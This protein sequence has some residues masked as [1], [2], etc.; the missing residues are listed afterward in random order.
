MCKAFSATLKVLARSW[1]RKL[2]PR[3]IDSFVNLSKLFVVNFM[4]CRV[5]QKN[6]SHLFTIHQKYGKNLKDYV[7]QFNQAILEVE[8]LSDKVVV[9]AMME[10]S[11]PG[12]LSNSLSQSVLE[13]LLA[14]QNKV[15]K[16]IA[17][18]ELAEAKRRRQGRD[19]HKKEG[20]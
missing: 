16:Y 9:M 18:E 19:D 11:H 12:P 13:T 20:T 1:F 8:D 5:R 17:T 6:A 4:S 14:L 15:D 2:C 3:T 7:R 10:G